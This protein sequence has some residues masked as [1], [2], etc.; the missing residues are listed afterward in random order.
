MKLY[1]L[2]KALLD[3][4]VLSTSQIP[5]IPLIYPSGAE[6]NPEP[7]EE[8]ITEYVMNGDPEPIGIAHEDSEITRGIYQVDVNVPKNTGRFH[9]ISIADSVA[10]EFPR[11][12]KLE[13]S[14]QQ[15]EIGTNKSL[16]RSTELSFVVSISIR[17]HVID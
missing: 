15:V 6:K 13:H 7:S 1:S 3:N 12:L 10:S 9:A 17:F 4:L 14:G 2:N 8:H 16:V 5:D 11:G